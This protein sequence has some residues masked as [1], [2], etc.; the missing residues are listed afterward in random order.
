M[1]AAWMDLST[2]GPST[3]VQ[4]LP[5]VRQVDILQAFVEVE[6]TDLHKHHTE[7][8]AD[9]PRKAGFRGEHWNPM[10]KAD[11]LI[12]NWKLSKRTE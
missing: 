4:N 11:E 2:A 6:I 12:N 1:R 9:S 7:H 10:N 5:S 3:I 8:H